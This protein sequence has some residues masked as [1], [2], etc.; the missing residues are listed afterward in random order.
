MI[1][2]FGVCVNEDIAEKMKTQI[3]GLDC[4]DDDNTDD[5]APSTDDKTPTDYGVK[6]GT[7]LYIL[8]VIFFIDEDTGAVGRLPIN[9]VVG[10]PSTIQESSYSKGDEK[11]KITGRIRGFY[12]ATLLLPMMVVPVIGTAVFRAMIEPSGL[13]GIREISCLSSQP[14]FSINIEIENVL[15]TGTD[16]G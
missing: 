16:S 3:P 14:L 12:L 11:D 13:V 4:D 7:I 5:E 15:P 9:K 10:G 1:S 8:R 6:A 2:T